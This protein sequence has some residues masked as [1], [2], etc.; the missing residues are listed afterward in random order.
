MEII[1]SRGT[2]SFGF[3][4]QRTPPVLVV[5]DTHGTAAVLQEFACV[6]SSHLTPFGVGVLCAEVPGSAL[7]ASPPIALTPGPSG[8]WVWTVSTL[9]PSGIG[10]G[11]SNGKH[12]RRSAFIQRIPPCWD[13]HRLTAPDSPK[14]QPLSEVPST[15]LSLQLSL[16]RLSPWPHRPWGAT[17]P[18]VASPRVLPPNPAH[19]FLKSVFVNLLS[20]DPGYLCHQFPA[21]TLTDTTRAW[22]KI[23]VH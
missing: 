12:G 9:S 20:N 4:T 2:S 5:T 18:A 7:G 21:G 22:I 23:H 10:L 8:W 3:D 11:P 1:H 16:T 6:R 14:P 13:F 19:T 15:Q 17:L